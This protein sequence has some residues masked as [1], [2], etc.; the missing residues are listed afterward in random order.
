MAGV[1]RRTDLGSR[2]ERLERAVAQLQRTSTL[3]SAS[4]SEGDLT[5]RRGGNIRVIDGGNIE[6]QD[7]GQFRIG[8]DAQLIVEGD[9]GPQDAPILQLGSLYVGG[10]KVAR[11]MIVSQQDG[12]QV[13]ILADD[14]ASIL[15][16][17]GNDVFATN[18]G[19]HGITSP[20]L[21]WQWQRADFPEGFVATDSDTW[22]L[23][24]DASVPLL[25]PQLSTMIAFASGGTA[26]QVRLKVDG[27]VRWTS[28]TLSS[29]TNVLADID[30]GSMGYP[31]SKV[32]S[33]QLEARRTAGTSTI[34]VRPYPVLGRG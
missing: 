10:R 11:G 16:H 26:G 8:H 5:V 12:T 21:T 23:L 29:S 24:W 31:P 7:E 3:S 32:S 13:A 4:I 34:A 22:T 9:D 18:R 1:P 20:R 33:V 27:A 2:L 6:L 25:H 19:G 14:G 15:D 17:R 30:V 28:E